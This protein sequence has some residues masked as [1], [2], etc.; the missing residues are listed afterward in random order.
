MTDNS[1][2]FVVSARAVF[3]DKAKGVRTSGRAGARVGY[4]VIQWHSPNFWK[5]LLLASSDQNRYGLNVSRFLTGRLTCQQTVFSN[6]H[7]DNLKSHKLDT[8]FWTDRSKEDI[9]FALHP[10]RFVRTLLNDVQVDTFSLLG[11]YAVRLVVCYQRFGAVYRCHLQG[12][13]PWRWHRYVLK[14]RW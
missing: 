11:C 10:K 2:K 5:S 9:K 14:K 7:C 13:D 1:F 3:D 12:P 8:D 4:D 6:Y